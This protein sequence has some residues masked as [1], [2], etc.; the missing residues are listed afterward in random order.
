MLEKDLHKEFLNI[1]QSLVKLMEKSL[2][3]SFQN[4]FYDMIS[5]E[6]HSI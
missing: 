5:N 1:I 4:Q 2:F 6:L 3:K